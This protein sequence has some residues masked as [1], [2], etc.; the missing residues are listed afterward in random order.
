MADNDELGYSQQERG[1]FGG[2]RT[3]HYDANGNKAGTSWQEQTLFS[4]ERTA[5]RGSDGNH[6]SY[7]RQESTWTGEQRAV[8]RDSNGTETGYSRTETNSEGHTVTRHFD[9]NGQ[10]VAHSREETGFFGGKR[11]VHYDGPAPE[12]V[13]GWIVLM[14]V[15]L[16]ALVFATYFGP[17]ILLALAWYNWQNEN[18][19]Q[20]LLG[21]V[22]VLAVLCGLDLVYVGAGPGLVRAFSEP[23]ANHDILF[24][25]IGFVNG[26]ALVVALLG[27]LR[28]ARP[29]WAASGTRLGA[30]G[31]WV[32]VVVL[33]VRGPLSQP[34]GQAEAAP[35]GS[36]KEVT[37]SYANTYSSSSASSIYEP[38]VAYET[39]PNEAPAPTGEPSSGWYLVAE[40]PI[41]L[42]EDPADTLAGR[43]LRQLT[44]SDSLEAGWQRGGWLR[45]QTR[46]VDSGE[47]VVTGWV[48]QRDLR[49]IS[50]AAAPASTVLT[51][52]PS[53]LGGE[54]LREAEAA[55]A[56]ADTTA[57]APAPVMG[58]RQYYGK[59]GNW[60]TALA[61]TW[62][63]QGQVRGTYHFMGREQQQYQLAG[64]LQNRRELSL[65]E[66]AQ[67]RTVG[68]AILHWD[69]AG[70]QGLLRKLDGQAFSMRIELPGE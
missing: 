10:E 18:T 32:T 15:G 62:N 12:G 7:S 58:L 46:P 21:A 16:L 56:A 14:V 1:L 42:W 69:G 55:I 64:Q 37:N 28:M 40:G 31:L 48:R 2:S 11:T 53:P 50:R 52:G 47:P 65:T 67:G 57:A 8:H 24:R 51:A 44:A 4:G 54:Q 45:V 35:I 34:I 39:T 61:L 19:R 17:V 43:P 5:H 3:D 68:H 63:E 70:Y 22:V 29:G 13:G 30:A 60:D 27:L 9:N 41:P 26:T 66:L 23:D 6:V 59:V 20:W 33:A 36:D 49:A 25:L 38:E